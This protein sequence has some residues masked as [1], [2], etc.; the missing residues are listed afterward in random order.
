MRRSDSKRKGRSISPLR[1][2]VNSKK[3]INEF[4]P[5]YSIYTTNRKRRM[6]RGKTSMHSSK[7]N[8]SFVA[9]VSS[10][11]DE[12]ADFDHSESIPIEGK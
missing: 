10:E 8:V 6:R 3:L 11:V 7:R 9:N 5:D 12:I 2:A 1:R 4:N